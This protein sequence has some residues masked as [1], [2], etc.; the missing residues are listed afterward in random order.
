MGTHLMGKLADKTI[1]RPDFRFDLSSKRS[2]LTAF[3]IAH[4]RTRT[5]AR[6]HT[7][8]TTTIDAAAARVSDQ[9]GRGRL[10]GNNNQRAFKAAALQ[11]IVSLFAT[12]SLPPGSTVVEA[13][14]EAEAEA[15]IAGGAQVLCGGFSPSFDDAKVYEA[16]GVPP[17]RIF[18][19]NASGRVLPYSSAYSSAS[20]SPAG[21]GGGG[22]GGGRGG[23]G[24]GDEVRTWESY[25]EMYPHLQHLFPRVPRASREGGGEG[26]A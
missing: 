22:G 19:V 14:A 8:T 21:G 25:V 7:H 20:A 12:C 9:N 1:G 24:E 17:H 15:E 4:T 11:Q 10:T 16:V 18:V 26:S 3:S 5:H 13:E 6:T 2:C 23:E